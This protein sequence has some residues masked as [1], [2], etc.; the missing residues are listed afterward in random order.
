MPNLTLMTTKKM[1]AILL[2]QP[3]VIAQMVISKKEDGASL[4]QSD[5]IYAAEEAT[6]LSVTGNYNSNLVS[7]L[8]IQVCMILPLVLVVNA[9]LVHS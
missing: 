1:G 3:L 9:L 6:A 5:A 7:A 2:L 4:V 8:V